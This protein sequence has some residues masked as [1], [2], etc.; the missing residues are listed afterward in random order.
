M[1]RRFFKLPENATLQAASAFR[2][3]MIILWSTI[4][5]LPFEVYLAIRTGSWQLWA[6]S[7]IILG[8]FVASYLSLRLIHNGKTERAVQIL[9][10][11]IMV[12]VMLN[13]FLI[14]NIGLGLGF[15]LVMLTTLI[16][17]QASTRPGLWAIVGF[18]AAAITL[19]LD[20]YLPHKR[21]VVP[22]LELFTPVIAG[23]VVLILA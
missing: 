12:G 16:S 13:P 9:I 2:Y 14:A 20:L 19:L 4:A 6:G 11:A 1:N 23:A 3:A 17:S 5:A 21:L 10:L 8:V 7:G 15:A 22:A 18:I